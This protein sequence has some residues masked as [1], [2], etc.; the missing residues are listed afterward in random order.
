[1]GTKPEQYL[2]TFKHMSETQTIW[3][4]DCKSCEIFKIDDGVEIL[5]SS[6]KPPVSFLSCRIIL[7]AQYYYERPDKHEYIVIFSSKGIEDIQ[8]EWE[9]A[10][11]SKDYAIVNVLLSGYMFK[12][13]YE[14]SGKKHVVGT[15]VISIN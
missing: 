8:Q 7:G 12:P 11:P 9:D 3:N 14:D 6:V 13:I 1:M 15:K 2:Y 10:Q 5:V 4:A